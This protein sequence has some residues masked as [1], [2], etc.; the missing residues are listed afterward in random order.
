M[1]EEFCKCVLFS[2]LEE[3]A[4]VVLLSVFEELTTKSNGK[5]KTS[6]KL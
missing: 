2:V 6:I 3:F 1:L 5:V 4:D